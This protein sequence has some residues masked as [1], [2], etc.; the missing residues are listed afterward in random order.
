LLTQL[1]ELMVALESFMLSAMC[2]EQK[3]VAIKNYLRD[4]DDKRRTFDDERRS[5]P[6]VFVELVV[7][8]VIAGVH[9]LLIVLT[10][11]VSMKQQV[12]GVV[13]FNELVPQH[14]MVVLGRGLRRRQNAVNYVRRYVRDAIRLPVSADPDSLERLRTLIDERHASIHIRVQV[15]PFEAE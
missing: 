11:A 13:E 7:S 14:P 4:F 9:G 12:Q 10:V 3:N 2:L 1:I 15:H 8:S 6:R 5:V